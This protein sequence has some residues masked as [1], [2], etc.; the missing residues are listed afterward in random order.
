MTVEFIVQIGVNYI[1]QTISGQPDE[2]TEIKDLW[3]S[4]KL[5]I[6]TEELF[7][8]DISDF[9]VLIQKNKLACI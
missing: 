2:V 9:Q 5:N 4:F 6:S 1:R 7:L 8:C 3:G